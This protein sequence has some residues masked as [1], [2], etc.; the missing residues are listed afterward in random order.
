MLRMRM[1]LRWWLRGCGIFGIELF[2]GIMGGEQK[3]NKKGT[4]RHGGL[5]LLF[6]GAGGH[7]LDDLFLERDKQYDNGER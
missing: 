7:A 3:Q 4:G 6:D 2:E 1:G 5:P